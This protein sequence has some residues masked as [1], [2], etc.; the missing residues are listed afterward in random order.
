VDV[1]KIKIEFNEE[2]KFNENPNL[3]FH[4]ETKIL[5]LTYLSTNKS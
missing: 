5:L 2:G 3:S 1:W 4:I